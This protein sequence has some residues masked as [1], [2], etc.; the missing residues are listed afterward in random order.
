[1]QPVVAWQL[2]FV[3]ALEQVIRASG[4]HNVV[5]VQF[6]KKQPTAEQRSMATELQSASPAQVS[7]HMRL[8]RQA[9]NGTARESSRRNEVRAQR[10]R[11]I[12]L[13]HGTVRPCTPSKTSTREA[14]KRSPCRCSP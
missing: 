11:A 7:P 13:T 12:A 10:P 6:T 1:M 8:P 9:F 5:H 3:R 2:S 14:G 4:L